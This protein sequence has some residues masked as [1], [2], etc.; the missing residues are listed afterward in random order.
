MP[1]AIAS[2]ADRLLREAS[3]RSAAAGIAAEIARM[4]GPDEVAAAVLE[5]FAG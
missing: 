1:D 5:R 2:A 4:P 3:F